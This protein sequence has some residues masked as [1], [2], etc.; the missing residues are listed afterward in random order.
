M[1]AESLPA[2]P[3]ALSRQDFIKLSGAGITGAF[4]LGIMGSSGALAQAEGDIQGEFEAAAAEFR[5][6]VD[7]LLAMG[8]VN[9]RWEMPPPEAN[10]YEK[11]D[12]HG[13]GAYGIMQLVQNPFSDTLGEASRLTGIPEEE[14]KTDRAANIRGGAALLAA[15][16]GDKP[17]RLGDWFGAVG[18]K[19]GSGKTYD[20][21]AGVG[22][23]ELFTEQ[24]TNALNKGV[25][26]RT[27]GGERVTLAARGPGARLA[28]DGKVVS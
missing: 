19:G 10:E 5:V 27:M 7:V 8:Y 15:S 11:G 28:A 26:G 25:S 6:P 1:S 13:W 18:G 4:L 12:L 14:L 9:S 21:V 22:A 3:A 17:S 23:G 2:P 16:Q 20:A 24:V